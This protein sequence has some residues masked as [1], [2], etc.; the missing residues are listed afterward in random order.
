MKSVLRRWLRRLAFALLLAAIFAAVWAF[1]VEPRRLVVHR[2][3]ITVAGLPHLRIAL[4]SDLHAGARFIDAAKVRRVIDTINAESPDLVLLLGDYLN[5]GRGARMSPPLPPET[6]A[7][8]LGRLQAPTYAVL[9]NHDWWF[10]G[11]RIA[12]ALRAHGITVLENSAVEARPGLWLAGIADAM[13]RKPSPAAAL[14]Q[15]PPGAAVV[16]LTHNPDVF[17]DLPA[18]IA[19]TVAGHTHGGQVRLP[20]LGRLVVPSDH[21]ERYAAGHIVENGRHLFVTTGVGTSIYPVRFGVPPE[22]VILQL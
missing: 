12:A 14:A 22:I 10:D 4:L 2:E 13:T 21:G 3:T 7:A 8:E 5:N 11:T 1:A 6:V 20:W 18:R 9:G 17:A 15:I 16:A 19:L